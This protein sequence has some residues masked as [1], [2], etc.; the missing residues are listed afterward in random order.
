MFPWPENVN[1]VDGL[2][3]PIVTSLLLCYNTMAQRNLWTE[4]LILAY[5][6]RKSL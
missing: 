6:S 5:G 1:I 3:I 4:V 2:T